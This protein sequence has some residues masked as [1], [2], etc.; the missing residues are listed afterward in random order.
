[1]T[2]IHPL[3]PSTRL[4]R[5]LP[6]FMLAL[7]GLAPPP[8]RADDDRRLAVP[9]LPLYQ[10][11]CASCHMAYPPGLLPAASWSRLMGGLDRH[12][13]TDASLDEA[14]ITRISRW[15]QAHAG[16]GRR[17][18]ERPP[19]DRI[20]RSAWFVRQHDEVAPAVWKRASI[21]SPAHCIACHAGADRGDFDEDRVRIPR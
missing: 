3:L 7:A 8:V 20:T 18:L 19:E 5:M 9:L 6:L 21:G 17:V 1:M 4:R 2:V 14:S 10:Q 15:L 16:T 13:G 11:E 12:Y